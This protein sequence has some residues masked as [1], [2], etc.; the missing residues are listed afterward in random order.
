[1]K[2]PTI[3]EGISTEAHD[4]IGACLRFNKNDRPYAEDLL[5][6]KFLEGVPDG[7]IE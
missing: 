3:P 7:P 2:S 4:F 6:F 5:N 1:M